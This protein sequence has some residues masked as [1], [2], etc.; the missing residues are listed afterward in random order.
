MCGAMIR[1][2]FALALTLDSPVDE[3]T[4]RGCTRLLQAYKMVSS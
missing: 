2:R 3:A 4:R 1:I